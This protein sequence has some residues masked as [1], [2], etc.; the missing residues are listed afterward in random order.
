M[1][2]WAALSSAAYIDTR[3]VQCGADRIGVDGI[4]FGEGG[5]QVNLRMTSFTL[6][7]ADGFE[8]FAVTRTDCNA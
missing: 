7:G 2:M 4:G 5:K 3:Q 8:V 1:R 6:N